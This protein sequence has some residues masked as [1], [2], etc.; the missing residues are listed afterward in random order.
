MARNIGTCDVRTHWSAGIQDV[1]KGEHYIINHH[2]ELIAELVTLRLQT[3]QERS[4]RAT[5][6]LLELM[7]QRPAVA[8]DINGD[9]AEGH[10]R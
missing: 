7:A 3:S 10:D 1:K 5:R 4:T 9:S 8:V 6:Q 2:G